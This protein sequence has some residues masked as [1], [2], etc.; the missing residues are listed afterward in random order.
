LRTRRGIPLPR[1]KRAVRSPTSC[2][3]GLERRF[4]VRLDGR[5]GSGARLHEDIYCPHQLWLPCKATCVMLLRLY[6]SISKNARAV[7]II[8]NLLLVLV[9]FPTR[10]PSRDFNAT[11]SPKFKVCPE[12]RPGASVN[13]CL[14]FKYFNILKEMNSR[15]IVGLFFFAGDADY[16]L[17]YSAI[18]VDTKFRHVLCKQVSRWL[19]A[20]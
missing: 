1:L 9:L 7:I 15:R 19:P 10:H 16:R 5:S 2:G 6:V 3:A 11:F 4:G 17:V 12:S 14:T 13:S 8:R 20:E 18:H